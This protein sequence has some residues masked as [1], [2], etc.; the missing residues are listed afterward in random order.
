MSG[1]TIYGSTAVC[2]PVGKFTSCIDAG[3]GTFSG[4]LTVNAGT[5]ATSVNICS[6]GDFISNWIGNCTSQFFSIRNNTSV[7]VYLNTQNSSPLILGVSTGTSGGSVVNH[8]SIASTGVATFVCSVSV[9]GILQLHLLQ[10]FGQ[11]NMVVQ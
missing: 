6:N 3:S 4:I 10:A 5:S 11:V 7:G 2:S 8:L 1:T 9:G